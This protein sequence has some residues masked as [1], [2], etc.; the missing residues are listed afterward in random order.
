MEQLIRIVDRDGRIHLVNSCEY[1]GVM[2]THNSAQKN[3]V[4][5]CDDLVIVTDDEVIAIWNK[6]LME[7]R[8]AYEALAK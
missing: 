8:P 5:K 2:P 3:V 1:Y 7:Y 4:Q 6:L